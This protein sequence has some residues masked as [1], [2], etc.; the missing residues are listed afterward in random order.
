MNTLGERIKKI[1]LEQKMT[2]AEFANLFGLS[3]SHISNIENNREL[4][5]NML[6]LFIC[7]KFY[8]TPEWL[9]KG[10]GTQHPYFDTS[11]DEGNRARLD[12]CIR[13]LR[14]HAQYTTGTDL[15]HLVN[16][17]DSLYGCI[18]KLRDLSCVDAHEYL[19]SIDS[20]VATMEKLTDGAL[21]I[22][23]FSTSNPPNYQTYLEYKTRADD[24]FLFIIQQF[25]N[26]LSLLL[27][28][29]KIKL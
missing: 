6:I 19:E 8:I 17:V 7:D 20:I 22:G 21:S 4:P 25:K 5:S 16:A 13:Y 12:D 9:T 29:A 27:K 10:E 3:P 11:T 23:T 15:Q 24:S 1:R 18:E 14:Y 26:A 28:D 2:Q